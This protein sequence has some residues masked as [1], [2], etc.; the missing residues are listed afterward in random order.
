MKSFCPAVTTDA[1][2]P[3]HLLVLA[4]FYKRVVFEKKSKILTLKLYQDQHVRFLFTFKVSRNTN[5]K[6]GSLYVCYSMR[7]D[8]AHPKCGLLT[9][10][11]YWRYFTCHNSR[12]VKKYVLGGQVI[13]EDSNSGIFLLNIVFNN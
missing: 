4:T 11:R 9:I 2:F 1:L 10:C 3:S 7:T 8:Q 12:V 13:V 6:N 5:M